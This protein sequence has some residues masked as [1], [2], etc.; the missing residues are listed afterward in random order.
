MVNRHQHGFRKQHRRWISVWPLVATWAM[1]ISTKLVYSRTS[2]PDMAYGGSPDLHIIMATGRSKG[3][4]PLLC[5]QFCLSPQNMSC[6]VLCLLHLSI[7]SLFFEVVAANSHPHPHPRCG[8][9][10]LCL[11]RKFSGFDSERNVL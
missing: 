6:P 4:S 7:T 2:D 8:E 11:S 3:H 9:A 5:L 10:W 1:D